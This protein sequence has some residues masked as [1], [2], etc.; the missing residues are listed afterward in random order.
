MPYSYC[1]EL[2]PG[3]DDKDYNLGF[4]LPEEKARIAGEEAYAGIRAFL[5]SIVKRN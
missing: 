5:G 1:L 3:P 4:A 2:R